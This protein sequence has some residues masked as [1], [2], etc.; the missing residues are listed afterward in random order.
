MFPNSTDEKSRYALW[1]CGRIE[2]GSP[3]A[4]A[5]TSL[6][7][8][9]HPH[10]G[11][12]DTNGHAVGS[13]FTLADILIFSAFGDTLSAEENPHVPPHL[14]EPFGSLLRT[15]KLLQK[16]PKVQ[17]RNMI[18]CINCNAVIAYRAHRQHSPFS[19]RHPIMDKAARPSRVLD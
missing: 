17:S 15:Q 3:A 12:I 9:L 4:A 19:S 7:H 5:T 11:L 16:H 13:Q 1:Y 10:S 2:G 14:R 6:T 8:P 18:F